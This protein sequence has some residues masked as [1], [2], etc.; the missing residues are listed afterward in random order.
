MIRRS[1]TRSKEVAKPARKVFA[2]EASNR[3]VSEEQRKIETAAVSALRLGD[4]KK[5][6]R[7]LCSAPIAPKCDATF[8]ALEALHPQSSIP[9]SLPDSGVP[10]FD[11]ELVRRAIKTFGPGSAGL[12]G[13]TP[14]LLQQCVSAESFSFLRQLGEAPSFL[15]PFLAGGVSIALQKPGSSRLW[16]PLRRLVAKCFCMAGKDEISQVFKGTN[17]GLSRRS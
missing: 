1:S 9:A 8:Q 16:R 10:S 15:R 12:F 3:K 14:L 13:Y 5:A 2:E 11:K 17:F 6:L 4:V 7:T